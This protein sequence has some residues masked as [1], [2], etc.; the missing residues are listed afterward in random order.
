[1]ETYRVYLMGIPETF[2]AEDIN[3]LRRNLIR[4]YPMEIHDL[5]MEVRNAD[6]KRIGIL[7][8]TVHGSEDRY[9]WKTGRKQNRVQPSTGRLI[10]RN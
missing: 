1:M 5:G 3:N 7:K 2:R 10:G 4:D 9:I 6:D 8:A